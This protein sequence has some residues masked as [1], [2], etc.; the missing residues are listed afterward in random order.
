M[1][2]GYTAAIKDGITFEKFALDCARAFGAC[3]MMR[4]E[5]G[6]GE[7]I[8][9]EFK[10]SDYHE[11]NAKQCRD[12]LASLLS[13]T[14]QDREEAAKNEWKAT[15]ASRLVNLKEK[16]LLRAAYESMLSNVDAWT[17]PTDEH[18]GLKEFM[19][20]QIKE[21]IDFD[22]REDYYATPTPRLNGEQWAIKEVARLGRDIEYHDQ[23]NAEEIERAAGRT[24]W[25]KA[26]RASLA[27]QEEND[28]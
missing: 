2:T 27:K 17:P 16:R 7:A 10:P 9:D 23:K 15:E 26:L 21:S 12:A 19:R 3:V 5:P 24:A 6:G 28:G 13:M 1:P 20:S 14:P 8:P 11:R 25:V 4:D 22:C 18:N